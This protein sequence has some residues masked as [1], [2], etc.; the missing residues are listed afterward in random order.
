MPGIT[1]ESV[2]FFR[3]IVYL[4]TEITEI[5]HRVN[6]ELIYILCVLCALCG[7]LLV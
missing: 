5:L 1:K 6:R 2:I 3:D 7:L 4:T